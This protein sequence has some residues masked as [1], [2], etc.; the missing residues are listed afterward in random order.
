[1][2]LSGD[3]TGNRR[4]WNPNTDVRKGLNNPVKEGGSDI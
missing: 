1:M 2:Q 3:L 4:L